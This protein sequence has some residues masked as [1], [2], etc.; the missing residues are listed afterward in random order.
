MLP[1]EYKLKR[2]NDFKKIFKQGR[3]SRSGFIGIK[4]LKNDLKFNRFAFVI[5]LKIS[6]KAVLRNKIRRQLEEIVRLSFDQM[7]I[8]FD[9]VILV[10]KE[11]INKNYQEIKKEIINLFKKIK[12][13]K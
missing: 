12:L 6:K 3:Y 7:E 5:G 8:G 13:I 10:E 2:D 11:I 9:V 1:R 4:F